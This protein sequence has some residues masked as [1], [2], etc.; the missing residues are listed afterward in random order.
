MSAKT[1]AI[2]A[3]NAAVAAAANGTQAAKDAAAA[4][5][6]RANAMPA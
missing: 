6:A 3:A 5:L 1:D 4:Q 2:A